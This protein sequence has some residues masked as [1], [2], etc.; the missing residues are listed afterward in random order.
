MVSIDSEMMIFK[1]EVLTRARVTTKLIYSDLL[2][3]RKIT[4]RA[5]TDH[6][7]IFMEFVDNHFGSTLLTNRCR[8]RKW[9][10]FRYHF[11]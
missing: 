3:V 11:L 6:H 2:L 8:L 10:F 9:D 1:P 7:T 5:E 4:Y